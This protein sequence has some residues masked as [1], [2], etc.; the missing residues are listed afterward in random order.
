MTV[1]L[2]VLTAVVGAVAVVA[3]LIWGWEMFDRLITW[4]ENRGWP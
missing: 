1:A 3:L 2:I 4:L